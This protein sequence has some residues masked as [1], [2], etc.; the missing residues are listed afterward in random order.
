MI[1][2]NNILIGRMIIPGSGCR[3]IGRG[4]EP[5]EMK[6]DEEGMKTMKQLG[7]SMAWLMKKIKS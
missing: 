2:P 6:N 3:N 4:R 1:Q 7:R 5:G